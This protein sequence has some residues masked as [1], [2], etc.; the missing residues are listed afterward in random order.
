MGE[1]VDHVLLTHADWDHVLGVGMSGSAQVVASEAAANRLRDPQAVDGIVRAAG[2]LYVPVHE[3]Q[4]LRVDRTI[5][6]PATIELGP[7][8][9]VVH[10]TPGHTDDG[11]AA[12]FPTERLLVVGD[13][14]SE[15]EIPFVNHSASAYR[16]TLEHLAST[17]SRVRPAYVVCGHG[18]PHTADR[19]LEIAAEDLAYLTH[20]LE[21][22]AA[23]GTSAEADSVIFP[24]RGVGDAEA[25]QANLAHLGAAG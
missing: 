2:K 15:L 3:A 23:G 17:I 20:L 1:R 22:A 7:W 18:R 8:P 11:I 19:A 6:P 14:L 16:S 10:A 21:F 5:D 24:R 12:W 4:R 9:A 25:H 13:Y